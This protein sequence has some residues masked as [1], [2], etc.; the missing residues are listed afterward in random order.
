MWHGVIISTQ[1]FTINPFQNHLKIISNYF[2]VC[3]LFEKAART[4]GWIQLIEAFATDSAN[5][6]PWP[7]LPH[8]T[9]L[10]IDF[11]SKEG[12]KLESM[13][14]QK[15][16]EYCVWFSMTH[17]L[18]RLGAAWPHGGQTSRCQGCLPF[19]WLCSWKIFRDFCFPKLMVDDSLRIACLD[20]PM[21]PGIVQAITEGNYRPNPSADTFSVPGQKWFHSVIIWRNYEPV[22]P[23]KD[24]ARLLEQLCVKIH[25]NFEAL[26]LL[27]R[28]QQSIS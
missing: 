19:S 18:N 8:Q 3:H 26:R 22:N 11:L 15:S 16:C 17:L 27:W 5:V 7:W 10:C 25:G 20:L 1:H 28:L 13:R 2:R 12:T 21:S 4:C 24:P 6:L 23:T 14:N 9:S